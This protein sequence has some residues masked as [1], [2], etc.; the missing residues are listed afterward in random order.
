ML[1]ADLDFQVC[2]R[3][4]IVHLVLLHILSDEFQ[5]AIRVVDHNSTIDGY[6]SF[7]WSTKL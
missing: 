7:G 4:R 2:D 6:Q 1:R 3:A 5:L